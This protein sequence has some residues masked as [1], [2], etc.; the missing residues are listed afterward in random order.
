MKECP[1]FVL[2]V[3]DTIGAGDAFLAVA[4]L[5]A[6]AGADMEV[7]TFLGNIAGA[8]ASNIVGNREHLQKVNILKYANTLLNI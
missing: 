4:G 1:A 2:E 7:G 8:L 6:A 5:S 3:M